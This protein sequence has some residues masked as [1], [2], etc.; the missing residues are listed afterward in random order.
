LPVHRRLSVTQIQDQQ[1]ELG[2][3]GRI[4]CLDELGKILADPF[5]SRTEAPMP[6]IDNDVVQLS[7][8]SMRQHVMLGNEVEAN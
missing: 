5:G 2:L 3:F 6:I 4:E 1:N 7:L 8:T